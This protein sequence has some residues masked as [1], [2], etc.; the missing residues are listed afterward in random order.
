M[1]SGNLPLLHML[2]TEYN[3]VINSAV[4]PSRPPDMDGDT[5]CDLG[6]VGSAGSEDMDMEV[7]ALETEMVVLLSMETR[8]RKAE[9]LETVDRQTGVKRG[10]Y[11]M[12]KMWFTN[13]DTMQRTKYS[14]E[15][16]IWYIN[17][18]ANPQCDDKKWCFKFRNRFRL[19]YPSYLD[20]VARCNSSD[21][22][23][24]GIMVLGNTEAGRAFRY[25]FLC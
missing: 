21:F 25:R 10:S 11:N 12:S 1:S 23:C 3:E 9:V 18:I 17:Y 5:G 24:N 8:K 19:P 6:S 22:F 20:L 4:V 2:A 16:S 7:D 15:F 13:P 14:F